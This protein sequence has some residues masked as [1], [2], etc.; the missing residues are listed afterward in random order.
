MAL[1]TQGFAL[2]ALPSA[3]QFPTNLG[4]VGAIDYGRVQDMALREFQRQQQAQELALQQAQVQSGLQTQGQQRTIA[5]QAAV[6]Q[7][8][9]FEA[10]APQR[11]LIAG[12]ATAQ[13]GLLPAQTSL[14]ATKLAREQSLVGP[15]ATTQATRFDPETGLYT[16]DENVTSGG[17]PV[18]VKHSETP[19]LPG[20]TAAAQ[21]LKPASVYD[22][23]TGAQH[24]VLR[25]IRG[26]YI[27]PETKQPVD[28][29][30]FSLTAPTKAAVAG[31]VA[32][33][34]ASAKAPF[35]GQ[36]AISKEDAKD[37]SDYPSEQAKLSNAQVALDAELQNIAEAKKLANSYQP[38]ILRSIEAHI[39]GTPQ[40]NLVARLQSIQGAAGR[41]ALAQVKNVRSLTEYNG[42]TQALG[43]LNQAQ[44]PAS[45]QASLDNYARAATAAFNAAKNSLETR[46]AQALQRLG[47]F[48]TAPEA[49][50]QSSATAYS[51]PNDVKSAVQSGRLTADQAHAILV[52]QFGFTP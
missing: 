52:S 36:A 34:Q 43:S 2:K 37:I 32:G 12:Q 4:S 24:G 8:Q 22:V 49:S 23:N 11:A 41:E 51:S 7:Q 16:T 42:L 30:H 44:D 47:Q 40:Y 27:D 29:T 50:T 13:A 10:E 14:E 25:N 17:T 26:D 18:S 33:A 20:A 9:Q 28:F 15:Q 3:P 39:P 6:R 31:E 38:G 48:A 46:H 5:G 1:N 19:L 45:L 21:A 35:V